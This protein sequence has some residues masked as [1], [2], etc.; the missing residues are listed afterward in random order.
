MSK[1]KHQIEYVCMKASE[2]GYVVVGRI[3]DN[4]ARKGTKG[5]KAYIAHLE[6]LYGCK[7]YTFPQ[8]IIDLLN[9]R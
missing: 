9:L 6:L 1:S 3:W 2:E 8:D 5:T 4:D 7:M